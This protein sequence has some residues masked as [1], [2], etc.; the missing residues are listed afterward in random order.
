MSCP[1]VT[2]LAEFPIILNVTMWPWLFLG[3]KVKIQERGLYVAREAI[4]GP[5]DPGEPL[6]TRSRS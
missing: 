5:S 1:A 6:I 4:H 3:W 2:S